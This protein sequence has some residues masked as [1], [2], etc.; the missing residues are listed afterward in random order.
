LAKLRIPFNT[1]LFAACFPVLLG[2]CSKTE[3]SQQTSLAPVVTLDP[4]TVGE[5]KGTVIL[6]GAPPPP[7]KILLSGEPECA[8]LNPNSLVSPIVTTGSNGVLANVAVYIK[9]GLANYHFDP[10]KTPVEL[11]QENCMYQPRVLALMTNQVLDIQNEDPIQHNVHP[12]PHENPAFN[13]TQVIRGA[14]IQRTF[15]NPEL[16]I[17]FMCNL[18]PWMRAYVFVFSHPYFAVTTTAGA[19]DLKNVPPGT[20]T[21][22][23]WQEKY[24]TQ[25]QTVTVAPNETKSVMFSFKS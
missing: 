10:P 1:L 4:N 25:D 3:P 9:S 23:A 17:R 21:I 19:F 7:Q 20:Y 2:G 24:G 6:D 14:P 13:M 18:H 8:Q 15:A 11:E 5:I 16:A 12:T 22:E